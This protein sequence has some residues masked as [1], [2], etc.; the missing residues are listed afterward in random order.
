MIGRQCLSCWMLVSVES[1]DP[2]PRF[3]R[4]YQFAAS[5]RLFVA[6]V[7]GA[8]PPVRLP[9]ALAFRFVGLFWFACLVTFFF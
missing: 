5:F 4:G 1:W 7:S 9:V 2:L 8:R 6:C 3:R